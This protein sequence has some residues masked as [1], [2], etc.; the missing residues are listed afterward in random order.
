[1]SVITFTPQ[2]AYSVMNTL[3]HQATGDSSINVV[4]TSTFIDAGKKTLEAGYE[5][6]YNALGVLIGTTIVA[7]RPYTGKFKLVAYAT[8]NAFENR[9]RKISYYA[10]DNQASGAF[11]TNLYTNLGDGLDFDDGAGSQWEQNPAIP[12]ERYFYSSYVW[13]KSHTQYIEQIKEAFTN[14][15]DFINFINGVMIEVQNDIESTIEARN[16]MLVLDRIAGQYL[17]AGQGDIGKECAVNLTSEFNKEFGTNYTTAQIEQS[18][19][20]EFCEFYV[21]YMKI[22]SDR[23]TE[24]TALYHDPMTLVK[25]EG[26][27]NEKVYKVLRHTPKDKQ[28]F[29]YYAPFFTKAKARVFPEIFNPQYLDFKNGEGV[30]FWQSFTNPEKVEIKPALPDGATS[31]NVVLNKVIGL[32]FDTDAIGANNK[33]EG[34]YTTALDARKLYQNMWWHYKYGSVQDYSENAVVLYMA[35]ETSADFTGDGT[36]KTF[37]VSDKPAFITKV[38]VAGEE[39]EVSSY[40]SSTGVVTLA[41]APA[42]N[43]AVKVYYEV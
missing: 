17:L 19:L 22:L 14:E 25:N 11:N 26:Q 27:A 28:K 15:G 13:D 40:V 18:H 21:A 33:F 37:T 43:A 7:A 16:R 30:N 24:R 32:I 42:N 6:V 9:I 23:L 5:N 4:D 1:M 12:V 39:V 35:D 8:A 31:S 38:T 36:A 41:S 20:N 2:D 34:M 29:I 10:R 3:V